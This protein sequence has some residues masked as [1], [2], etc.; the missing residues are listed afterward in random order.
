ML[1]PERSAV[2]SGNHRP[3]LSSL[4]VRRPLNVCVSPIPR[5]LIHMRHAPMFVAA[6]LAGIVSSSAFAGL[7]YNFVGPDGLGGQAEFTLVNSTTL[8][9]RLQNT[10]TG[11]PGGFTSAAQLL[12]SLAFNLPGAISI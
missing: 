4:A 11:V 3:P 12:T 6:S 9:V 7:T 5:R 2:A 10:S 8:Q 1:C